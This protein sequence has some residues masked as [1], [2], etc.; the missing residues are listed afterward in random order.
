M[1]TRRVARMEGLIQNEV[2]RLLLLKIKDSR[3]KS[4]IVTGEKVTPDLKRA[5]VYYGLLDAQ[6][7]RTGAAQALE[8]ASG[9][10]RREIAQ[11][12]KLRFAPEIGFEY[13]QALDYGRRMDAVFED[14]EAHRKPEEHGT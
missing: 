4:I 9:F 10:F 2:S 13:D 6:A 11:V 8:R 12:L 7:D 3:L 14:L 1:S 5:R